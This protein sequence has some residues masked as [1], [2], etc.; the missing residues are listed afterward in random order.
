MGCLTGP[1]LHKYLTSLVPSGDIVPIP[2]CCCSSTFTRKSP[3]PSGPSPLKNVCRSMYLSICCLISLSVY[4]RVQWVLVAM[5]TDHVP[6]NKTCP[7]PRRH[8]S[9]D[10]AN[11]SLIVDIV[12]PFLQDYS[13][14]FVVGRQQAVATGSYGLLEK[15]TW[16][17]TR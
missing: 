5:Q 2:I 13:S 6:V 17:Q 1:D 15:N 11:L 16:H 14:P 4:V 3:T 7:L 12:K 10:S 8:P 9:G